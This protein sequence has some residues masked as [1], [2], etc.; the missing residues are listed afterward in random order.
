MLFAFELIK[1]AGLRMPKS[2]SS[3]VSIVGGLILGQAAVDSGF[4]GI[5]TVIIVAVAGMSGFLTGGLT[6]SVSLVRVVSI[7]PAS[8]VGLYGLLLYDLF[9]LL[10]AASIK[11]FG[12]PYLA[13]LV[14]TYFAD[15]KDTLV[16]G[17]IEQLNTSNKE[18]RHNIGR[19][20]EESD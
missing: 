1:E 17:S 20:F 8:F 9:L 3:S 6:Q 18:H 16:R 19:Y 15:W 7:I 5:P 10:T 4:I 13:P 12:V 14:P 11:S 2:I